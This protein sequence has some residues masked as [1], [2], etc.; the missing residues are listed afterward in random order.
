MAILCAVRHELA[1]LARRLHPPRPGAPGRRDRRT[2]PPRHYPAFCGWLGDTEVLLVASGVGRR[3]AAE[4]AEHVM[5]SWAPDALL[6]AGVAGA[7]DPLLHLGRVVIAESVLWEQGC[8]VPSLSLPA[9]G[10]ERGPLLSVD[11]VLATAAD[12]LGALAEHAGGAAAPGSAVRLGAGA[13]RVVEMETAGAVPAAEARGVPWGAV[14]AVSDV[15]GESLPF[16]FNLLRDESGDIPASRVAL[17]ACARP[18]CIPGLLRLGRNTSLAAAALARYL[19]AW[20]EGDEGTGPSD[21]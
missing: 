11:R 16:D 18:R 10:A 1:P 2:Q 4:A 9:P 21:D 15:A 5:T 3:C 12:K 6:I 8:L 19:A 20:L 14:R 13:P 7:L 17:M